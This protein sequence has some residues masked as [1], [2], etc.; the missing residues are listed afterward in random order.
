MSPTPYSGCR[1]LAVF[2]RLADQHWPESLLLVTHEYGVRQAMVLGGCRDD[3]EASYCG[4][5][6]LSRTEREQTWKIED[7]VD[8]YKYDNFF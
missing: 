7:Y 5:V 1:Y 4:H 3:V 8:V 6:E 2:Q